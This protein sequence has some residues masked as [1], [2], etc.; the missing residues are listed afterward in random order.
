MRNIMI[1][2]FSRRIIPVAL[3]LI[4]MVAVGC[5]DSVVGEDDDLFAE[6]DADDSGL[7]ESD[8]FG[9][10]L[11]DFDTFGTF[12]VDEDDTL[13]SGEFGEGVF[14]GFDVDDD[15]VLSEEE[16]NAGA[17]FLGDNFEGTFDDFDADVDAEVTEDEF[18]TSFET[19]GTDVVGDFDTDADDRIIEDEL[20][21]G[22]FG[23]ADADLSG[24]VDENEFAEFDT[25][26]G[27]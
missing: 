18:A 20:G 12:D 24:A 2:H 22:F 14:G 27:L 13:D 1:L 10:V 5:D 19:F 21:T 23:L 6:F 9:G 4:V 11:T 17:D 26:F 25:F 3:S 8:E 16:F 7:L 15:E